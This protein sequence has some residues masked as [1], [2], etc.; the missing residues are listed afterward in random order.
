MEP[1]PT[2]VPAPRIQTVY[3][4]AFCAAFICCQ[5]EA[6]TNDPKAANPVEVNVPIPKAA[7]HIVITNG[8]R[9]LRTVFTYFPYPYVD[10]HRVLPLRRDGL[11]RI[12]RS[13]EEKVTAIT[14]LRN[15]GQ[16]ARLPGYEEVGNLESR[17]E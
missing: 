6:A 1:C 7:Q 3:L 12:E 16:M 5:T 15:N 2:T 8:D 9:D 14:I 17:S 11:Y 13:P 10:V 4:L